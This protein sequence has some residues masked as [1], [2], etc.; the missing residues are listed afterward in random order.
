MQLRER[1]ST[2]DV[3]AAYNAK[4]SKEERSAKLAKA[5]R[6]RKVT[7]AVIRESLYNDLLE[8]A[9]RVA[10]AIVEARKSASALGIDLAMSGSGPSL[11]AVGDDRADAIRIARRLRRAGLRSRVLR[12]GVTP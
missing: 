12:L 8:A 11:F 1:V 6:D 2:A 9:E 5:L 7:V 3:F 4:P 10:P